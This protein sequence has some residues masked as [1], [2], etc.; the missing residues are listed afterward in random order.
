[1]QYSYV[2]KRGD[3]LS[4]VALRYWGSVDYWPELYGANK[5]V[6]GSD[7][8]VINEGTVLE[9]PIN[10]NFLLITTDGLFTGSPSE[11]SKKKLSLNQVLLVGGA[12]MSI[13]ALLI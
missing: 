1:M 8:N 10:L 4:K 7:P 5:L 11:V 3:W 13:Y 9:F 2:T 12:L 6:I